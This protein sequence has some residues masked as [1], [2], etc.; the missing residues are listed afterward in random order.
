MLKWRG[1]MVSVWGVFC[2]YI[3]I[4]SNFLKS[5]T[6][7]S[8]HPDLASTPQDSTVPINKLTQ[9]AKEILPVV[10]R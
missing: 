2:K 1:V 7:Q 10:P 5:A 9:E 3:Y 8:I 4:W 6:T